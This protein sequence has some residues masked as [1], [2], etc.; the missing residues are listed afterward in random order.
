MEDKDYHKKCWFLQKYPLKVLLY[1]EFCII[2]RHY[3]NKY[4]NY[5]GKKRPTG[6]FED[7]YLQSGIRQSG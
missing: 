7:D 5:E 1:A 3:L 6:S 2:L 4:T